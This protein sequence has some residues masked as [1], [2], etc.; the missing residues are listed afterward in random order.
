MS[1]RDPTAAVLLEILPGFFVHTFGIGHIYQGRVGMGL[2]IMLS[3]WFLQAING[4][5]CLLLIGFV[6]APLTWFFYLLA[7]PLNAADRRPALTRSY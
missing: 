5:L 3:Y 1:D 4:L 2:F 6:T 7:A